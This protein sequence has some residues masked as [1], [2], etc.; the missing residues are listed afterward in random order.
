[1][2][3]AKAVRR[4]LAR[5]LAAA[6]PELFEL[7]GLSKGA[8]DAAFVRRVNTAMACRQ[9]RMAMNVPA[10]LSA[11]IDAKGAVRKHAELVVFGIWLSEGCKGARSR[12]GPRP[13][14]AK[15]LKC[16]AAIIA[17]IDNIKTRRRHGFPEHG[18]KDRR[19]EITKHAV[20]K[21]WRRIFD[22]T[23]RPEHLDS[24]LRSSALIL[25]DCLHHLACGS[26]SSPSSAS[27]IPS[28]DRRSKAADGHA[29]WH[30]PRPTAIL[31]ARAHPPRE[32][33]IDVT[34]PPGVS[35]VDD[36]GGGLD[37]RLIEIKVAF[38]NVAPAV[39]GFENNN[40][41]GLLEIGR[42]REGGPQRAFAF[43]GSSSI[44]YCHGV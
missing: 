4:I 36:E 18:C 32:S 43:C 13:D 38:E 25:S 30:A 23:R 33:D 41:R 34:L 11:A 6:S 28:R 22:K 17:G 10:T 7:G 31:V 27:L 9:P 40:A 2:G 3:N 26:G 37:M 5:K 39:T 35:R 1:M 19:Q 8:L 44:C 42:S 12:P 16:V 14:P 15:V 21:H 29:D 24:L 20:A